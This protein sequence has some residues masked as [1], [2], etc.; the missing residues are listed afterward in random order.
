M[1]GKHIAKN[2]PVSF[3]FSEEN[4]EKIKSILKKYPNTKKKKRCNAYVI[5]CSKTK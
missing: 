2:Q 4:K 5:S 3:T 1:S